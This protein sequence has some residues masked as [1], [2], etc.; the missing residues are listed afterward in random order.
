[1]KM[2]ALLILSVVMV[3]AGMVA[4]A[5]AKSSVTLDT[6]F[7]EFSC[8]KIECRELT[9]QKPGSKYSATICGL[10]DGAGIW[11]RG[12]NASDCVAI[13]AGFNWGS[14]IAVTT[15]NSIGHKLAISCESGKEPTIQI[16]H[17]NKPYIFAASE[18]LKIAE[19]KK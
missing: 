15:N 4:M 9:V 17:Q 12:E 1:M 18:L 16:I 6:V 10:D 11:I 3:L 2:R 13:H 19:T 8:D 14:T 5:S 7:R